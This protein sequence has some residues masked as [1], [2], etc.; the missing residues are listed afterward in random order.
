MFFS[1][2]LLHN[3]GLGHILDCTVLLRMVGYVSLRGHCGK[4]IKVENHSKDDH[5]KNYIATAERSW[6]PM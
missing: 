4:T 2:H 6:T 3:L 5:I 1:P